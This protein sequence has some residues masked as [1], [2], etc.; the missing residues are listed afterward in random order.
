MP[1][2]PP[3][4]QQP[5]QQSYAPMQQGAA[6]Q[7]P[8]AANIQQPLHNQKPHGAMPQ[9]GSAM[10][11]PDMR[12]QQGQHFPNHTQYGQGQQ[13]GQQLQHGP[14]AQHGQ[15][16]QQWQGA[17]HGQ[18]LQQGP[19]AQHGQQEPPPSKGAQ[20]MPHIQPKLVGGQHGQGGQR[21]ANW[22]AAQ[23]NQQML[24]VQPNAG[25]W[26]GQQQH[27]GAGA[28]QIPS[29]VPHPS[30]QASGRSVEN[31]LV[32]YVL[33]I[34][35][36]IVLL[37]GVLMLFIAGVAFGLITEPVRCLLGL[38][39][40]TAMYVTGMLQHQR[41]KRPILGKALLGGAHGVLII[42]ISIAHLSY[43][44][45]GVA[46]A[47]AFYVLSCALI[48]FSAIRWRSQLLVCIA[49]ISAYLCMY[50]IDIQNIHIIPYLLVQLV[51]SVS[52]MLLSSKLNYR[53]AHGIA[54]FL[55]HFSL[56]ITSN[57]HMQAANGYLIAALLIQHL[58]VF[59]QY[60]RKKQ[61]H[62]ESHIMQAVGVL[63]TIGWTAYIYNGKS[64][65][66]L[67][68]SLLIATAY[69]IA[70]LFFE[71]ETSNDS[72]EEQAQLASFKLR[73]EISAL[74]AAFALLCFF[75][76]LLGAHYVN[77]IIYVTGCSLV[78][79]GLRD[80]HNLLRWLGAVL[81]AIGTVGIMFDPLRALF[82]YEMLCWIVLLASFPVIYRECKQALQYENQHNTS[83]V[84]TRL[85]TILWIEAAL[86]FWFITIFGNLI[87]E[88]IGTADSE[89]YFV[90]FAWLLYA[91]AAIIYGT[92]RNTAKARLTG[93]ILLLV[94]ASKV[95]FID[96]TFLNILIKS[97]LFTV[98]GG[99][100]ILV[101][102]LLYN[103][104]DQQK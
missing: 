16:I 76:N 70:I 4:Q 94:I 68:V 42:T 15:Q 27:L 102:Y 63:A 20:Q 35:F 82:S 48:I 100:G 1:S 92:V 31:I 89:P 64:A 17:Q 84:A 78:L 66:F 61:L 25:A 95:V 14:G 43:E 97:I 93:I 60:M 40:A 74:M 99:V 81:L 38:L 91:V 85:S 6:Q 71:R 34:V 62:V 13:Q 19:G 55:L 103:K 5:T 22:Q 90:S 44:L 37:I 54:Y 2:H 9:S 98:L 33:P 47:V 10:Q 96:I 29:A 86:A 101:S 56:I 72:N 51:I 104:T 83:S 30:K 65:V 75:A 49:I 26:Q 41:S 46:V 77:L 8:Y 3:Q 79:Y 11:Q 7:A 87:G 80:A 45:F 67:T 53:Y 36:I 39:L 28:Q 50:L 12:A 58:V 59:I 24:H 57:I 23:G 32:R 88:L 73:I 18:Q 52:M 21:G 69:A